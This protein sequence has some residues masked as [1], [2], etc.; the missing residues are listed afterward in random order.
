MGVLPNRPNHETILVL[1][2]VA[3]WRSPILRNPHNK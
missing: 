2:P 3:T 1:K